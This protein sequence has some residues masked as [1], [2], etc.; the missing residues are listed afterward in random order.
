MSESG[1]ME[2]GSEINVAE[3]TA[4]LRKIIEK[5][6]I[7]F[8]EYMTDGS[9]QKYRFWKQEIQKLSPAQQE[10]HK[11]LFEQAKQVLHDELDDQIEEWR[12]EKPSDKSADDE[13]KEEM[14]GVLEKIINRDDILLGEATHTLKSWRKEIEALPREAQAEYLEMFLKAKDVLHEVLNEEMGE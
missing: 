6:D 1:K 9:E 14:R 8:T 3:M 5:D 7:G 4:A 2:G 10:K 12:N 11:L 13:D